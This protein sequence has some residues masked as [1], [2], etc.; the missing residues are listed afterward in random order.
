MMAMALAETFL[1]KL[2][3]GKEST[4]NRKLQLGKLSILTC[5]LC[6]CAWY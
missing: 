4:T 5:T 6:I 1:M 2:L 3:V